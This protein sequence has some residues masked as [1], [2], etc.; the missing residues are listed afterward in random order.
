MGQWWLGVL[1]STSSSAGRSFRVQPARADGDGHETAAG[2]GQD[3]AQ[4][5]VARLLDDG[6]PALVEEKLRG[7]PQRV[8][9][10][11]GHKHLVG[12]GEDAPARQRV[13]G[14]YSRSPGSSCSNW[15]VRHAVEVLQPERLH[16]A[17]PPVGMVEEGGVGLAIDEGVAV[18]APVARF[19]PVEVAGGADGC[20]SIRAQSTSV[21]PARRWRG[22]SGTA[23][24]RS[25][26]RNTPERPSARRRSSATSSA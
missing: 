14:M 2:L 7:Q 8:L 18:V 19:A 21:F 23:A 24:A 16:H 4:A 11:H 25:A 10:P 6:T 5:G 15:F 12:V 9:R 22:R 13:A 26:T 1:K 20:P 17:E 3:I